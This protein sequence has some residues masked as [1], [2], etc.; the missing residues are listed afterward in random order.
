MITSWPPI[1]KSSFSSLKPI[2][3]RVRHNRQANNQRFY[4]QLISR[5]KFP[6]RIR[7]TKVFSPSEKRRSGEPSSLPP[8]PLTDLSSQGGLVFCGKS[9]AI[10]LVIIIV[11]PWPPSSP[12]RSS[13]GTARSSWVWRPVPGSLEALP[14]DTDPVLRR[15]VSIIGAFLSCLGVWRM[16]QL[17][18]RYQRYRW[19]RHHHH[20]HHHYHHYDDDDDYWDNY[21]PNNYER[22]EKS[23]MYHEMHHT[24]LQWQKNLEHSKGC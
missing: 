16:L 21:Y 5:E 24:C 17:N 18:L 22:W 7:I 1:R 10:V 6:L 9:F 14:M 12:S 8:P 15:T 11:I 3:E 23:I 19:Y 4:W 13:P 20:Y 2:V